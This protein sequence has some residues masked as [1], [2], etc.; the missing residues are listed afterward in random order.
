MD[1]VT[2]KRGNVSFGA[3]LSFV[4]HIQIRFKRFF[5]GNISFGANLS[6]DKHIQIRFKTLESRGSSAA[7]SALGPAKFSFV[8]LGISPGL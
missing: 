6:F 8:N 1:F 2:F 7:T 5:G 4:K 3:N